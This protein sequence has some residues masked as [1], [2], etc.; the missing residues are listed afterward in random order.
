VAPE[1]V[2]VGLSAGSFTEGGTA[3]A[4]VPTPAESTAFLLD[5]EEVRSRRFSESEQRTTAAAARW[6][7]SYNARCVVS[8]LPLDEPSPDGSSL[9]ALVTHPD[10]HLN[11]R[12]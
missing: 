7:L 6:V 8:F 12:W 2:L 1:P 9:H 10:A 11:L 3:G 5:Y 4:N